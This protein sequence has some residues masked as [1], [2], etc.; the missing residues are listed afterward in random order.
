MFGRVV[1]GMDVVRRIMG[2]PTSPT[3]GEGPM[4]G[5]MIAAPIRIGAA[6]RQP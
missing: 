3:E 4:K 6:R 1:E 2:A 5:Q